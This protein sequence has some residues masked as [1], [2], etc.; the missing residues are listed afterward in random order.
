[1]KPLPMLPASVEADPTEL[2]ILAESAVALR[3]DTGA[4][5]EEWEKPLRLRPWNSPSWKWG[6]KPPAQKIA[7]TVES[8]ILWI[9]GPMGP[10]LCY[11]KPK[12]QAKPKCKC[13]TCGSVHNRKL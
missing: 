8:G 7:L 9:Q 1:M 13:M 6:D 12:K 5:L 10:S 3:K 2:G 11:H 4:L